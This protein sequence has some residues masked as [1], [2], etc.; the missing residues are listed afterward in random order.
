MG[1]LAQAIVHG[2][3]I[4]Q[5]AGSFDDALNAVRE[6]VRPLVAQAAQARLARALDPCVAYGIEVC[7][8]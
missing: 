1:K 2:A 4:V 8:A 3:E 6:Q 7:D 5:I